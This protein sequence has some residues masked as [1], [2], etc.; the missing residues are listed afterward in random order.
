MRFFEMQYWGRLSRSSEALQPNLARC[1]KMS[2]IPTKSVATGVGS[3]IDY[4]AI[5]FAADH[6]PVSFIF[7][8][9]FT[10]PTAAGA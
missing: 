8:T 6:A 1:V 4:T 3:G 10:S 9:T 2:A 7:V 5:A